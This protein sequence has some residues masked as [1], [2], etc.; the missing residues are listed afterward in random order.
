MTP[1]V[2]P[3]SAWFDPIIDRRETESLKWEKYRGRDVIPLWV[4]DMDFRSPPAVV[5]ALKARVDHGIFGYTLP[6]AELIETILE[7]LARDYGWEVEPSWLVWLPGLV[8][9]LNVACRAVGE[10]GAGVLTTVPIYP[11][12]LSAPGLARRGLSTAPM[13]Q[14]GGRWEFDLD[15]LERAVNRRTRL[16]LLCSPHNPTGRVFER[17]ELAALAEFCER[18]DLVLCSDEIHSGLVL[19]PGRVHIPTATL[20][21]ETA[22]R[23]ITLLAP[24][25]TFNLPGLGCAFAI[26]PD[27]DLRRRF[28]R[29]MAGIV[30]HV[31]TLGYTAAL[32][33]YRDAGSWHGELLTYLRAN[34]D[35]V[36]A[37]VAEMPGLATTEVEAT[38]LAWIDAKGTGLEDPGGFFEAAGVGLSDGE[39]FGAP[40]FLRLNFGCPRSLLSEALERMRRGLAG[41]R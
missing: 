39:E 21:P 26:V 23:T 24:S 7:M 27:T 5:D 37:A 8:T 9:G 36:R 22:R 1:E 25:K 35:L 4:A 28:R 13:V 10:D 34:R 11:P 3:F 33:A 14:N 6:P 2:D 32:A 18:H 16:L 12:F 41:H 19:A 38:Y 30:P 20:G 31:N 29:A 15:R 40:G 17:Y